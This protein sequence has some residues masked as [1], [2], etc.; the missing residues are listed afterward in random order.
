MEPLIQNMHTQLQDL[1][2]QLPRQQSSLSSQL[3]K[4]EQAI[5]QLP[6]QSMK[7]ALALIW[8]KALR[9]QTSLHRLEK[10]REKAQSWMQQTLKWWNQEKVD[11]LRLVLN[12]LRDLMNPLVVRY[13][14]PTPGVPF[15]ETP[16]SDWLAMFVHSDVVSRCIEEHNASCVIC[17][18]D[19]EPPPL[20]EEEPEEAT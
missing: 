4:L 15:G 1:R 19:F 10:R 9:F 6:E 14:P 16:G 5:Q 17:L 11:S 2:R 12:G 18:E 3:Q 20:V 8:R 7:G 13:L